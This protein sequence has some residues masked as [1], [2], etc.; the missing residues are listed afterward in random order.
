MKPDWDKL[1]KEY[2]DSKT[3]LIGDVDCTADSSKGLCSKFG[4]QGYPTIKYFTSNPAGDDYN[5]GR[6][7][8]SLQKWAKENLGPVCGPDNLD[9]CSD[10]EKADIEEKM[11]M[12]I[13]EL[14]EKIAAGEKETK[15]ADE[16]L[17]KLI[18]GLQSQYEAAQKEKEE[19]DARV[20]KE[21]GPLRGIKRAKDAAQAKKDEL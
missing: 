14:D 9:L 12:S 1:G 13:E 17:K 11:K 3:A 15:E 7:F 6:D 2:A 5:G 8:A 18:E 16:K 4:V 19:T 20:A 21:L 10:E